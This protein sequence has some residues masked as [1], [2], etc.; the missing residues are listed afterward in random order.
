MIVQI[1]V[2]S[3]CHPPGLPAERV[4]GLA[5]L[6]R[7]GDAAVSHLPDVSCP[8]Q[9]AGR[10]AAVEGNIIAAPERGCLP[11]DKGR[12]RTAPEGSTSA[13][14]PIPHRL[15]RSP[16]YER[17]PTRRA[18]SVRRDP[19]LPTRRAGSVRRDPCLPT[20]DTTRPRPDGRGLRL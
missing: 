11:L 19:C 14:L 2:G 20:Q 16:L 15:R 9:R 10:G 13:A 17:G 8:A 5:G 1:C 6:R 18:G 3:S 7:V 4:C 12:W